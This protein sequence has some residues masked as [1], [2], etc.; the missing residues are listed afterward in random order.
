[1]I[2]RL[3]AT[4]VMG[5]IALPVAAGAQTLTTEADVSVGRSTDGT[6]A[7]AAQVRVFGPL[8]DSWRLYFE[9][10]WGNVSTQYSDAFGAAYPYDGRVR[11]MEVFTERLFQPRKSLVG[12][13]IG[14]YRTPFGISGRS[15]YAYGGFTRAPLIRYDPTYGLS[16]LY[17]E[18]GVDV[19]AGRPALYVEG[20]VGTAADAGP[21]HRRAGADLV[22]RTQGYY[23]SLIVGVS[24]LN[25]P[26]SMP[27]TFVH[28][29]TA[30][31]GIDARW[32]LGGVELRGEWADGEPFDG[33]VTRG[34]YLDLMV[35]Q[36]CL[37]PVTPV[38]RVEY[39]DYGAGPFSEY[40]RRMTTGVAVRVNRSLAVQLDVLHQGQALI[41]GRRTGLDVGLTY[42]VRR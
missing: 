30:F 33:V 5:A 3:V 8:K 26:P 19:I 16:N 29:R 38:A 4:V 22:I 37:G 10:A 42:T 13:R 14:R 12:L 32:M 17:F 18:G 36:R 15:D 7:A 35:H 25:T 24:Y 20:S 2:R 31:G 6:D 40:P 28:G 11:P 27:G 21:D 9:A 41:N 34:G 23:H 1:V 39:L